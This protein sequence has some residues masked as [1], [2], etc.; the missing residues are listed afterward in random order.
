[1]LM[2]IYDTSWGTMRSFLSKREVKDEIVNFNVYKI[3]RESRHVGVNSATTLI[4]VAETVSASCWRRTASPSSPPTPSEPVRPA[5][6]LQHGCLPM[7]R[8]VPSPC[9]FTGDG[10]IVLD[11]GREDRST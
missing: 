11:C 6:L 7:F 8:F 5:S 2:G 1:M 3:T 4:S 9:C 10:G